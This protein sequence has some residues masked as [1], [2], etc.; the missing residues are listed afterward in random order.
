MIYPTIGELLV[1]WVL[2]SIIGGFFIGYSKVVFINLIVGLL[3]VGG[4]FIGIGI[5]FF[6][7]LI[8]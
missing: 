8:V 5:H 6:N 1:L 7:L 3:A 2:F 4:F